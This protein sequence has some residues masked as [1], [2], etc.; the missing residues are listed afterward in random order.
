M[1]EDKALQEFYGLIYMVVDGFNR[2][3][4]VQV[5]YLDFRADAADC[6]HGEY[7]GTL[8]FPRY[9]TTL[10]DEYYRSLGDDDN[11]W[12][13]SDDWQFVNREREMERVLKQRRREAQRRHREGTL[14]Y[15]PWLQKPVPYPVW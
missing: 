11:D 12:W 6:E 3:H 9:S 13:E 5:Q 4:D 1:V 10:I 8:V 15:A 14:K 2:T 7:D